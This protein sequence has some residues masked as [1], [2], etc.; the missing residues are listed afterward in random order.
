MNTIQRHAAT[1]RC[2][3]PPREVLVDPALRNCALER[4][5]LEPLIAAV[6]DGDTW[7][8]AIRCQAQVSESALPLPDMCRELV[9]PVAN[10][11][12]DAVAR[13]WLLFPAENGGAGNVTD[14]KQ[15]AG[16]TQT[17]GGSD[18]TAAFFGQAP[19]HT[20]APPHACGTHQPPLMYTSRSVGSIRRDPC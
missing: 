16:R 19:R 13:A 10:P 14:P 5:R 15:S 6:L 8:S 2:S 9:Q 11:V 18:T 1:L 4:S 20:C 12:V 7:A 3:M 17:C